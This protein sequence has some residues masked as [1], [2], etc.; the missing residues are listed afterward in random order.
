MSGETHLAAPELG[1]TPK[2]VV[3][4][5]VRTS[6]PCCLCLPILPIP[7]CCWNCDGAKQGDGQGC[8]ACVQFFCCWCQHTGEWTGLFDLTK[9]V[10][11]ELSAAR[12]LIVKT[13][14]KATTFSMA[15]LASVAL[16]SS[17]CEYTLVPTRQKHH[18]KE[19]DPSGPASGA[20][21]VQVYAPPSHL[22]DASPSVPL[23]SCTDIL[24]EPFLN[25]RARFA[26]L[27]SCLCC[28]K[29]VDATSQ[30]HRRV[31]CVFL[32]AHVN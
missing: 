17:V 27:G 21:L 1:P 9:T 11:F 10:G 12:G 19:L 16:F 25:A 14:G 22:S 7:L 31:S 13:K 24:L 23:M 5:R 18:D 2:E 28:C 20:V 29:C 26:C 15:D 8:G 4:A 3:S 32:G 30:V 6:L